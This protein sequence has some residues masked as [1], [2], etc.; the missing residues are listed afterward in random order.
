MLGRLGVSDAIVLG[1]SWGASVAAALGIRHPAVVS[2]LILVQ[3]ITIQPFGQIFFRSHQH[4][5][6]SAICSAK[7]C[8]RLSVV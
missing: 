5:R 3:D 6:V 1:H 8:L 4:C 7:P 2:K